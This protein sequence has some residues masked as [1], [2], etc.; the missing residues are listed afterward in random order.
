MTHSAVCTDEEV[1]GHPSRSTG[2]ERDTESGNDYFGARYFAS[3]MGRMLSP[4]WSAKIEPVPY[5]K[6]GD[7]QTLNLYAYVGNNPLSRFDVDGHELVQLGQHTDQQINDL[8]KQINNT[9]KDKSLDS[10]I[11]GMLKAEKTTLG[12]EKEGNSVVSGLLSKLDQ[13][14]QRNGLKLSDFTL[15]TSTA[16]DFA[17]K[18]TPAAIDRMM[19]A[20]AFT[21]PGGIYIRTEPEFGFY[22]M[23]QRSSDFGY[24]GASA[25][26]HEQVHRDGGPGHNGEN[27]AFQMQLQIFEGFK[28]YFQN[29][30]I[31]K[32]LDDSIRN[33]ITSNPQ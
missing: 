9:L 24:Y 3:S 16:S 25:L 17:G 32:G 18:A 14:G 7:P 2:K 12:L 8:T 15:S 21:A 27:P 26:R 23:S 22:Q 1:S 10:D 29:P 4:D 13:T 31:Y 33:G 11:K 5:S 19:G 30:A 20:Q 6:L 28:G